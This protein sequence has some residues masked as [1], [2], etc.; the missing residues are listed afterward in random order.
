MKNGVPVDGV[1]YDGFCLAGSGRLREQAVS[2]GG[3]TTNTVQ[4]ACQGH[5]L[6]K[7]RTTWTSKSRFFPP[8]SAEVTELCQF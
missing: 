4:T 6:W 5:G 3:L 7:S 8:W 2:Q 1:L